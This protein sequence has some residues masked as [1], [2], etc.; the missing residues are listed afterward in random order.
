LNGGCVR[1]NLRNTVLSPFDRGQF[2][3]LYWGRFVPVGH[4]QVSE[5]F[6]RRLARLLEANFVRLSD[7]LP[8]KLAGLHVL[9]NVNGLAAVRAIYT[10]ARQVT[11]EC[12]VIALGSENPKV[13]VNGRLRKAH[14]TPNLEAAN[15]DIRR[16]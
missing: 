11:V 2:K 7:F 13:F 3:P 10:E 9:H 4:G 15:L 14:F 12:S 5:N 1:L 6:G 16:E 8:N